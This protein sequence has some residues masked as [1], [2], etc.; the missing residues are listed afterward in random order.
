MISHNF[1]KYILLNTSI[2]WDFN[3]VLWKTCSMAR[4]SW[5]HYI[6]LSSSWRVMLHVSKFK[7]EQALLC[8][9]KKVPFSPL[10]A[11]RAVFPRLVQRSRAR[12]N[13]V[14]CK[15]PVWTEE[16]GGRWWLTVLGFPRAGRGAGC[17]GAGFSL[18]WIWRARAPPADQRG[19]LGLESSF[20]LRALMLVK[21][22]I[23]AQ[24]PVS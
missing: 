16:E 9:L 13:A 22:S 2:P 11:A 8:P 19:N 1:P 17:A 23:S 18:C 21:K 3:W 4:Y 15:T 14:L 7:M 24:P 10:V 6:P 12:S 5:E 20:L